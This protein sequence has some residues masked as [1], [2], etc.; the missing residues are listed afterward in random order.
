MV[1]ELPYPLG[2]HLQE[3]LL[4]IEPIDQAQK[5]IQAFKRY[6]IKNHRYH[7]AIVSR[8]HITLMRFLQHEHVEQRIVQKLQQL[9]NS[10]QPFEVELQNFGS[11]GH[12]LFI[13]VKSAD[14]ILQLVA[15]HKQELRPLLSGAKHLAPYFAA[16]PH[17]TI[18]R[19][20][21]PAQHEIIWPI[22]KRTRYHD[23]FRANNMVLLKRAAGIQS[24]YAVVRKFDFLGLL[25]PFIQGKL[26]A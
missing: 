2:Y 8:G 17:I 5:Q 22:W 4:I 14:P 26:F 7:N 19:N 18:A 1:T 21:T 24:R 16:K 10:I 23:T 3:Y 9:A 11:F 13:D 20:L 6:F 25:P 12:T 15:T